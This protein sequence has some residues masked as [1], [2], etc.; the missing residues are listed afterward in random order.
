MSNKLPPTVRKVARADPRVS[1]STYALGR[2][3]VELMLERDFDGITVQSILDRAGVG[4]STFY[5]HYRNKRD[6]LHSSY[7]RMFARLEQG[8][9][10]PS[11]TGA[12]L[13]PVTEFLAHVA[14]VGAFV[15]ALRASGQLDELWELGVGYLA[16][17]IERR[18]VAAPGATPSVPRALVA[19]MLAGALMEMVRWWLDHQ[20]AS[21]PAQ[22]DVV[23]HELAR[24][25]L[26]RASYEVAAA[27]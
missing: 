10:S 22:M 4:R 1:R 19:R 17:M 7:E 18:I 21:T 12:R 25:T 8:L 27:R 9:D 20:R 15:D 16:R 3:L 26:R 13:V 11:S 2:A 6:V 5:A 23:F 24:A 14:Q